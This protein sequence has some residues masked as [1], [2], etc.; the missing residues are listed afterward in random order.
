M[1]RGRARDM[2]PE[3]RTR[4]FDEVFGGGNLRVTPAERAALVWHLA[5][6]RAR[7]TVEALL[8][9]TDIAL[10]MGFDPHDILRKQEATP[11]VE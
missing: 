10:A 11:R 2:Q 5:M 4:T 7:K 3:P 1:P 6:F 8:P 9:E